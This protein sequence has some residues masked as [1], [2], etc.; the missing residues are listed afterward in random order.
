M[1]TVIFVESRGLT[2]WRTIPSSLILYEP[3]VKYFSRGKEYKQEGHENTFFLKIYFKNSLKRDLLVSGFFFNIFKKLI[4][5]RFARHNHFMLYFYL[6]ISYLCLFNC[7]LLCTTWHRVSFL[8]I[9]FL[10]LYI[11]Y[12]STYFCTYMKYTFFFIR[13]P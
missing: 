13:T 10:T 7:S 12:F 5:K 1:I 4:K 2:M 11:F 6:L 8:P 3:R 9:W